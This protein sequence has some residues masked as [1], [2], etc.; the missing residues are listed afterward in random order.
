MVFHSLSVKCGV[1]LPDS[2]STHIMALKF[3]Y[4]YWNMLYMLVPLKY[5]V[6]HS[7]VSNF[8]QPPL[9][10]AT[11]LLCSWDFSRQEY[12]NGL[13]FPSPWGLPNPGIEPTSL[14]SALQADSL[15]AEPLGKTLDAIKTDL[16]VYDLYIFSCLHLP[17]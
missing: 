13:P 2:K 15:P 1:E 11:G 14:V 17:S 5:F 8:L 9:T 6:S 3:I 10:V 16:Q 4:M 7:V 12:W